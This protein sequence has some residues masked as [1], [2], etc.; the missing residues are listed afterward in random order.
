MDRTADGNDATSAGLP[1]GVQLT[2][3]PWR[4]SAVLAAMAAVEAGRAADGGFQ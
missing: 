4:E 1:V 3:R 2:G